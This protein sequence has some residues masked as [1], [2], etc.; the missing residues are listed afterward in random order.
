MDRVSVVALKDDLDAILRSTA[1]LR[2]LHPALVEETHAWAAQLASLGSERSADEYAKRHRSVQRLG[3]RLE[4]VATPEREG[5]AEPLPLE[6]IDRRLDQVSARVAPLLERREELA[7]R[8]N[9]LASLSN[10]MALL[11]PPGVP[12][13]ELVHSSFLHTAVGALPADRLPALAMALSGI[14]SVVLPYRQEADRQRVLCI[15]LRR[16]A[17]TLEDALRD[18]GFEPAP[19]PPDLAQVSAES[20][21]TLERER[22]AAADEMAGL[23]R[24]IHEV[25]AAVMPELRELATGIHA[26]LVLLR[27]ESFCKGTDRTCLFS[28]WTPHSRS[29]EF[30]QAVRDRTGGRAVVEVIPAESVEAPESL[31][32]PVLMELPAFLKPFRA[33]T[34]GFGIP[35]YHMVDPTLF[36][37]ITF[38]IMFGM[39][40]GDVGHGLVLLA[41]GAALHARLPRFSD[42]ARLTIYCGLSSIVFGVLYGSVFGLEGLIPA[43]WL[44]PLDNIAALFGAAIAFGVVF[45][46]LGLALNI[47]NAIRRRAFVRE[48]FDASGPLAVVAYWAGVGLVVRASFE[49]APVSSPILAVLLVAPLALLFARGPVLRLLGRQDRAFPEGLGVYVMEGAVEILEVL[50]GFVANTVSF[51]R[52]AAF[53]LAH[54]ALFLAVFGIADTLSGSAFGGPLS[55]LVLLLGNA[56]IILL[57]GLVVVIQALRLEYYEFFG[58][59]FKET[60]TRFDPVGFS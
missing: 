18:A 53:G 4:A 50:M 27:V 2:I 48:F 32:V 46:S 28:G 59:F 56:V 21:R 37:A 8:L 49:S 17:R 43:L 35:A 29:A 23:Q 45:I 15:V 47:V 19:G 33:L 58:K 24:E 38:L 5:T 26:A 25:R 57:E 11:L 52:V 10:Q 41:A 42:A 51:I 31:D 16:D 1:S 12:L 3:E 9:K 20:L 6:D 39:M 60:G 36:V 22:D 54:A 13:G 55:I 40:F 14:P 44:R 34:E 30:V 7:G